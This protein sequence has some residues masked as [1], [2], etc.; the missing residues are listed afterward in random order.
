[1]PGL[2]DETL[3]TDWRDLQAGVCRIF[4]D[5]GLTAEESKALK[6]PRGTVE[7]DV[8]AVDEA[9]VDHISY[10]VECKRGFEISAYEIVFTLRSH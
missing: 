3:P 9:S 8:Y 10:I 1:M 2:I 6:T 4:Q 7:V 5:I